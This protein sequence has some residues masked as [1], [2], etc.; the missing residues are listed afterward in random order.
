M[1]SERFQS[2]LAGW[3]RLTQAQ[4]FQLAQAVRARSE[5]AAA[6]PGMDLQMA[7]ERH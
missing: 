2:C 6:L 1:T 3:D 4:W 5:G 7:A